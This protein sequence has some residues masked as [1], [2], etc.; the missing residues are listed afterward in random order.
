MCLLTDD[1]GLLDKAADLGARVLDTF[2]NQTALLA[3]K[4]RITGEPFENAVHRSPR[5]LHAPVSALAEI[6]TFSLEFAALAYHTGDT[7]YI[8]RLD[9]AMDVIERTKME[10]G[11]FPLVFHNSRLRGVEELSSIGA[12][13]DSYY[14]Y[15]LKRWIHSEVS[16]S[17]D[18][19]GH[20]DDNEADAGGQRQTRYLRK[21]IAAMDNIIEL[22]VKTNEEGYMYIGDYH[23]GSV[24]PRMEHLSCFVPGMLALG[25]TYANMVDDD[26]MG[27]KRK[28][29]YMDVARGVAKTCFAMYVTSGSK[30]LSPEFVYLHPK[31]RIDVEIPSMH[32]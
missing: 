4:M 10:N 6:G 30:G 5:G 19:G 23:D 18:D 29:T 7:S 1:C 21:W 28:E 17:V 32:R 8:A 20:H 25:V 26:V 2:S 31:V 9:A 16:S 13:G 12:K 15:L 22:M 24:L 27:S 3:G 11:L 14:E